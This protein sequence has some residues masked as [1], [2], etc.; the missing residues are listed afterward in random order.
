[1]NDLNSSNILI[2]NIRELVSY[3]K[4]TN[5]KSKMKYNFFKT[6]TSI[7]ESVDTVAFI[8]STTMFMT[9]LVTAV[10]LI[11][12]PISAGIVCALSL[13]IKLLHKIT[14]KSTKIS[15]KKQVQ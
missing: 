7:L 5:R 1:M 9:L 2:K 13:S 11:V 6:L 15:N 14:L 4:D 10:G 12:V 8:G 3:L